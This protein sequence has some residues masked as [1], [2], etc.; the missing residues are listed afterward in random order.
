MN[1]AFAGRARILTPTVAR[2]PPLKRRIVVQQMT[3]IARQHHGAPGGPCRV[4][5]LAH[6]R[7]GIEI[8]A[9]IDLIALE[10][11]I[12]D[13]VHDSRDN[14]LFAVTKSCAHVVGQAAT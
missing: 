12:V 2:L 13:D 7:R 4:E 10:Q 9:G 3:V 14:A 6:D 1:L 5:Q 11:Q 8:P